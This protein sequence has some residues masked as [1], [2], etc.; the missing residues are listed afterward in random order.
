MTVDDLVE[1]AVAL[2]DRQGI[3]SVTLRSVAR[4]TGASPVRV[5]RLI[6]SRD[7]L[8]AAM[9]QHVLSR[10]RRD[11]SAMAPGSAARIVALAQSEWR[12]YERHPWLVSVLASSRPPV[13]PA[14]LEHAGDVIDAFVR[15]GLDPADAFDRYIALSAYVQGMARLLTSEQHETRA[16]GV[17]YAAWWAAQ[18]RR[19]ERTGRDRR[20]PWIAQNTTA[21]GA[22]GHDDVARWFAAG[23]PRVVDGLL[24]RSTP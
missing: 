15:H 5:E 1:A 7:R 4:H 3:E 2:A 10:P 9:T 19:A 21:S 13:E 14:V 16:H 23:L 11:P 17:T 12:R 24:A 20:H 22:D 18:H 6:G 8:V